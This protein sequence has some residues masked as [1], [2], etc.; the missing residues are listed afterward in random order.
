M[1]RLVLAPWRLLRAWLSRTSNWLRIRGAPAV[2][3]AAALIT[4]IVLALAERPRSAWR[5]LRK[6][7]PRLIWGPS[8]ILNIKYWSAAMKERGY[9]STTC[10]DVPAVITTGDD[11]DIVQGDFLAGVSERI[12]S[13][14]MFAW[15]LRRGDVFVR[16]FDMGFLRNTP[17]QWWEYPITRL[18]GKK[19]IVMPYGG[20][21]AVAG[22]LGDYEELLFADYPDLPGFADLFKR[23]I[24]HSL[25]WTNLSIRTT[26][27]GYQPSSDAICL[28][29][30]GVDTEIWRDDVKGSSSDAGDGEVVVVHAPNHRTI[31][32]TEHLERAIADLR[33]DGLNVRLQ[34]LEG[35]NN[36]E[37]RA[38]VGAGDIVADQFYGGYGLFAVEGMASG[39]PV[40][41]NLNMWWLPDDVQRI[42]AAD[43]CPIVDTDAEHL[44]EN[45]RRLVEDPAMRREAGRSGREFVMRHHSYE[46]VGRTWEELVEHVWSGRP[47]P[48]RF[49]PERD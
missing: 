12:R 33:G 35:R 46:A 7:R 43:G 19:I 37:V 44:R 34:I 29:L 5:R 22:Y 45:L 31:K 47:L 40:L 14:A 8:A 11:F 4:L 13:Y 16:F 15:A 20:D 1:T 23:R 27:L 25:R 6:R 26:Q 24:H 38:A 48:E 3:A 41:S 49:L 28:H 21:V 10:V 2:I 36:A 32:G 30:I 9:E 42:K 39:K 18:A 17:L